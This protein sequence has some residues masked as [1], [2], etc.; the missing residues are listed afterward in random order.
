MNLPQPTYGT[1]A[2]SLPQAWNSAADALEHD[3]MRPVRYAKAFRYLR[4]VAAECKLLEVG[5]GQGAGLVLAQQL[6][7]KQLVGVEVSS[8]R[9]ARARAKLGPAVTLQQVGTDSRWPFANAEF[10]ACISCAVIEHTQDPD[11]FVREIARVVRPGGYIVISSDCWQWRILQILGIYR[12][13]QPI[14][15]AP[16]PTRLLRAFRQNQLH[17]I[18]AEGFPLPTQEFRF[19]R[20]TWEHL[21]QTRIGRLLRRILA[22]LRKG[23]GLNAATP[24]PCTPVPL[25]DHG[26]F[27]EILQAPLP[28]YRN[29]VAAIRLLFSDENVFFL[30][31]T[32]QPAEHGQ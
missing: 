17:L 16:F 30:R 12:S 18:H 10:D 24:A 6:G 31:K 1:G 15:T 20:M 27:A 4:S 5:C 32:G 21:P 22:K 3:P 8:E 23:L 2:E 29:P 25:E 11:A 19:V 28:A 13:V 26:L 7:F 14:D 9:L